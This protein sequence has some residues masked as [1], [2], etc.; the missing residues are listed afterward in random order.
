MIDRESLEGDPN[1]AHKPGNR[2]RRCFA[3]LS[4]PTLDA[5][6]LASSVGEA[7][8]RLS[9]TGIWG[10]SGN[11]GRTMDRTWEEKVRERA[12]AIW[13]REGRPQNAAEQHWSRAEEE[14]RAEEEAEKL[15]ASVRETVPEAEQVS[16]V[17]ENPVTRRIWRAAKSQ[18]D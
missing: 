9:A 15:A 16:G 8:I 13:E 4:I 5:D 12:H 11:G 2:F 6:S 18:E 14:L 7:Q 1:S 17:D 3:L 10:M